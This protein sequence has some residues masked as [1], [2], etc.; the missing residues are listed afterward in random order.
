MPEIRTVRTARTA[1]DCQALYC[2]ATIQPGEQ[3]LVTALTP[4]DEFIGNLTWQRLK[5]CEPCA[6]RWG[7][8]LA[9]QATPRRP[10]RPTPSKPEEM[11]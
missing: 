11:P 1:H 4:G 3:Y 9:E 5:I 2:E 10:R 8:T 6:T 7:Q